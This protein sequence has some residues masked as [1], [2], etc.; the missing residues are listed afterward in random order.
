MPGSHTNAQAYSGYP[1]TTKTETPAGRK[2]HLSTYQPIN[3]STYQ[4]INLST[5]QPHLNLRVGKTKTPHENSQGV[6]A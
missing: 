1:G 6:F 3:L 2:V 5:N 4:P